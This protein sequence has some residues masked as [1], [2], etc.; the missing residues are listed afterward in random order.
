MAGGDLRSLQ[1]L[2]SG[3]GE[4]GGRELARLLQAVDRV[5]E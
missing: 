1:P 4:E 5:L 2:W 3:Y